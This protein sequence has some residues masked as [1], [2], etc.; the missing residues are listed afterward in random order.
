[1]AISV[2]IILNIFINIV[3]ILS[4]LQDP[5]MAVP[6]PDAPLQGAFA[7]ASRPRSRK[8][9]KVG[10]PSADLLLQPSCMG[11]AFVEDKAVDVIKGLLR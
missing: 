11:A 10:S 2:I 4:C 5:S 6:L 8:Q 7:V 9:E 3:I 1:M